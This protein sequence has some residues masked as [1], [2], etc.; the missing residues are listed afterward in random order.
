MVDVR[1][2]TAKL[3]SALAS[4]NPNGVAKAMQVPPISIIKKTEEPKT[5]PPQSLEVN[6]TD[7]SGLLTSLLDACEAA[8]T[9]RDDVF[10]CF[11]LG[12][13]GNLHDSFTGGAFLS[14]LSLSDSLFNLSLGLSLQ[15]GHA[16]ACYKAQASLH[17]TF[18]RIFTNS[19][20]NWLMP[21]LIVVCKNTHRIALAADKQNIGG[22]QQHAK[23]ENAVQVLQDSYS[24]CFNDRT[25]LNVSG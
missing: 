2:K 8:E 24:K 15:Q 13:K 14:H 5:T 21:A 9:V 4:Q 11:C 18:N 17:S 12:Q 3:Q 6:D 10:V 19:E 22:R 23:L 16:M 20:G 7:Y 1:K 25:E